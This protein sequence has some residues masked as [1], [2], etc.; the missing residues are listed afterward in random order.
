MYNRFCRCKSAIE[1]NGMSCRHNR[2]I[3]RFFF[4]SL[5]FSSTVQSLFV[6]VQL[7]LSIFK[8]VNRPKNSLRYVVL[9]FF[10]FNSVLLYGLLDCFALIFY[11]NLL[12]GRSVGG[13]SVPSPLCNRT[14]S[15]KI[16]W[17]AKVITTTN[18]AVTHSTIIKS[19]QLR[20][21]THHRFH[22]T[23][24]NLQLNCVH[25]RSN[26][27]NNSRSEEGGFYLKERKKSKTECKPFGYSQRL[28]CY[29]NSYY[30]CCCCI[31]VYSFSLSLYF[32]RAHKEMIDA[33]L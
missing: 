5:L 32:A 17:T 18:T 23:V 24:Y 7:L 4:T 19:E 21:R 9:F 14:S 30:Y 6:A 3:R 20:L 15:K 31:I 33:H 28:L 11:L 27:I 29:N 26:Y 10:L 13:G 22:Q 2:L 25:V 1:W 12:V 8:S 16:E